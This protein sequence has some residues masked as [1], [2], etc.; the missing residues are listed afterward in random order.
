VQIAAWKYRL[1]GGGQKPL[2]N[3][4]MEHLQAVAIDNQVKLL[5]KTSDVKLTLLVPRGNIERMKR[6]T[7]C[8]I[9]SKERTS[10]YFNH[11][12]GEL[13]KVTI[14]V[15]WGKVS[16]YYRHTISA[17]TCTNAS[18]YANML[19]VDTWSLNWV[20][21]QITDTTK[22]PLYAFGNPIIRVKPSRNN[23]IYQNLKGEKISLIDKFDKYVNF[24][25]TWY[26]L[27]SIK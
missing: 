20:Y 17:N 1:F 19:G 8:K 21:Y 2:I 25:G 18:E 26:K 11:H 12:A 24:K 4:Q 9:I 22:V 14:S 13:Y 27:I 5:T 15:K 6:L 3:K 16:V 7:G 23:G 10:V